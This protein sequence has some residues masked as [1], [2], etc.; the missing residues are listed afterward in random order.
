ML[1]A[2]I[3]IALLVAIGEFC[4]ESKRFSPRLS[5]TI[6]G[7][8]FNWLYSMKIANSNLV[9]I[10]GSCGAIR[11]EAANSDPNLRR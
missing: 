10:V 8:F 6:L 1:F 3:L 7:K 2:G 11:L 4:I 9:G 5:L